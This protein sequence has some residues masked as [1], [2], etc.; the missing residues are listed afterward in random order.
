M[1]LKVRIIS[2]VAIA[3]VSIAI[4]GSLFYGFKPYRTIKLSSSLLEVKRVGDAPYHTGQVNLRSTDENTIW[5]V[6]AQQLWRTN[7]Q[8]RTWDLVSPANSGGIKSASFVTSQ[9]VF[10]HRYDGLYRT[11]DGG[12][13]WLKLQPTPFDHRDGVLHSIRF[14]D[15]KRGFALG[16][17]YKPADRSVLWYPNN[18]ISGNSVLYGII[19]VTENAGEQWKEVLLF[20]K[21]GRFIDG[22]FFSE[23]YGLVFG[24]AGI[25][26]TEDGGDNWEEV[27]FNEHCTNPKW[28]DYYEGIP[29]AAWLL[30]NI[31]LL[32]FSDGR[33]V[34]SI[35]RGKSWCDLRLSDKTWFAGDEIAF[36]KKFQFLNKNTGWLIK[37]SG[38]LYRTDNGGES[39]VGIPIDL[40]IED[41]CLIQENR[42]LALTKD[43]LFIVSDNEQ[44]PAR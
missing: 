37:S 32:G 16:G 39:W 42:L 30:D 34:K 4:L 5:L 10:L 20:S 1:L 14:I 28:H 33:L 7:D 44:K 21:V 29:L 36:L 40:K 12:K 22:V 35:D 13:T 31:D 18:T 17:K 3:I 19:W 9:T 24:D 27:S 6:D 41:I 38:S 8:G 26:Y 15:A 25:V 11:M 23:K 2:L 43:G